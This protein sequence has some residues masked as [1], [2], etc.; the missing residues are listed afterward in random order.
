MLWPRSCYCFHS[1]FCHISSLETIYCGD[2]FC[3][4]SV[5]NLSPPL[6]GW[7]SLIT[8]TYNRFNTGKFFLC[9]SKLIELHIIV[10]YYLGYILLCSNQYCTF[11]LLHHIWPF[12]V[13]CSRVYGLAFFSQFLFYQITVIQLVSVSYFFLVHLTAAAVS[14]VPLCGPDSLIAYPILVLLLWFATSFLDHTC[15]AFENVKCLKL[16]QLLWSVLI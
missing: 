7:F 16:L 6:Q 5:S 13:E 3:L 10:V 14:S 15:S 4:I 1:S 2:L 8:I 11:C 9:L 12:V